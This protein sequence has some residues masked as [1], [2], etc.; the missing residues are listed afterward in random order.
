[1]ITYSRDMELEVKAGEIVGRLGMG[2]VDIRRVHCIKSRGSKSRRILARIHTIPKIT[3]Q[4]LDIPAHYIIELISENFDKLS[5]DEQIR[6]IIH[7]L[8]HIPET[9]GGGFRHH[10]PYVTR[11]TVDKMYKQYLNTFR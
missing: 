11:R 4:A 8:M 7:E 3:Q 9:F 2:H 5:K 6:T 1:M 10:R